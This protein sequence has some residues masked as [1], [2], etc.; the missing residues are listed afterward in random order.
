MA[1][2]YHSLI[3][4]EQLQASIDIKRTQALFGVAVMSV[5]HQSRSKLQIK[6]PSLSPLA[7]SSNSCCANRWLATAKCCCCCCCCCFTI[8]TVLLLLKLN[9]SMPVRARPFVWHGGSFIR[10]TLFTYY[11]ATT[12]INRGR[13][14]ASE[15]VVHPL[16]V[17]RTW[18]RERKKVKWNI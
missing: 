12:I 4:N 2:A 6:S 11:R 18:W 14:S 15:Q 3:G 13:E 16:K 17:F 8:V 5:K 9:A 1:F 7:Y 10:S